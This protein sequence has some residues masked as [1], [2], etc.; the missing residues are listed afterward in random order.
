MDPHAPRVEQRPRKRGYFFAASP[1]QLAVM[2][3]TQGPIKAIKKEI[4]WSIEPSSLEIV[5]T[6]ISGISGLLVLVG[7]GD[8]AFLYVMPD[9]ACTWLRG[10]PSENPQF[11]LAE[12]EAVAGK[13]LE[14]PAISSEVKRAGIVGLLLAL[15]S[16]AMRAAVGPKSQSLYYWFTP[17][18]K[19]LGETLYRLAGITP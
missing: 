1:E 11:V 19:H 8:D 7:T 17:Q 18:S 13:A 16:H 15:R 5:L 4:P 9:Q 3:I 12:M 2:D 10:I 14:N 6:A